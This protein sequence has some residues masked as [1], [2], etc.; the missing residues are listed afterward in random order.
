MNYRARFHDYREPAFYM[1]T[2]VAKNR[3]PRFSTC[4]DDR[5]VFTTDG[6]I[7]HRFWHKIPKQFP[8]IE[9]STL[10]IM[11]DH[12]HGILRVTRRMAKPL[13]V[14]LRA[15]KSLTT[16]EVRRQHRAPA[17]E[18]WE[19][20]YHDHVL[21]SS[22]AL[23]A[24]TRYLMDNPRRFCLKK[25][26]PD[27]FRRAE[28]L[29]HPV[30]PPGQNW[31]GYGNR[32]LLDRPWKTAL[33]VSRKATPMEIAALR[34]KMLG[35]VTSGMVLVSPFISP[36]EKEIARAVLAEKH[37][38]VILMKPDGFPPGFKPKGRYF[39]LCAEGRLLILSAKLP[40]TTPTTALTR[41]HCMRMNDW[42]E[43][44]ADAESG[45]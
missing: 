30:L 13:G 16:G 12:I 8:E 41:E 3:L 2:M 44:M 9:T 29:A 15:F 37:G 36:G 31:A 33:R 24:W 6:G 40:E 22:N 45:A 34:E 23:R 4:A 7:V 19:P 21:Y 25:A 26:N 39:D 17:L 42:C 10:V 5:V 28:Q 27:L 35:A 14:A 1:I 11:P 32:F 38:E 20:G 43:H 18:V